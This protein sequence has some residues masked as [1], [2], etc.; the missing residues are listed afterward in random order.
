MV[1]APRAAEAEALVR[2]GL[3][4]RVLADPV[5]Q[6]DRALV[7][8]G[9]GELDVRADDRGRALVGAR[10]RRGSSRPAD[11]WVGFGPLPSVSLASTG[12]LT[13]Y[14]PMASLA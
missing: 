10:G 12:M 9:R 3:G 7:A 5:G 13:V 11:G 4:R 6:V 2:R 8:V 14:G 1:T